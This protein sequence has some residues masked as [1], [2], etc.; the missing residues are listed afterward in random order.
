[1]LLR[2]IDFKTLNR[3]LVRFYVLKKNSIRVCLKNLKILFSTLGT[4]AACLKSLRQRNNHYIHPLPD[5]I[6]STLDTSSIH[7]TYIYFCNL[8]SML[9]LF[10]KGY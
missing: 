4:G 6:S 7:T 9:R 5:D 8:C 1:M 10:K 2:L 3:T